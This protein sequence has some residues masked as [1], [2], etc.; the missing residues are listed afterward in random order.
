MNELKSR[1]ST[2]FSILTV[3]VTTL[4]SGPALAS[5]STG[6][7]SVQIVEYSEATL[8]LQLDGSVSYY[9]QVSGTPGTCL[10]QNLDTIKIWQS[11]AQSAYLAGRHLSVTY[12]TCSS[13]NYITKVDLAD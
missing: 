12:D 2:F 6:W 4:V 10:N 11:L 1:R 7:V 13:K 5:S 8:R 9:A 3:A